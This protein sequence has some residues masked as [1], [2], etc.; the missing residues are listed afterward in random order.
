MSRIET[1]PTIFRDAS[2]STTGNREITARVIFWSAASRLSPGWAT[3]TSVDITSR[4]ASAPDTLAR[5]ASVAVNMPA[6]WPS[7]TTGM[8]RM[9]LSFISCSAS[10]IP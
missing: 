4:T 7:L 8:P 5:S 1:I 2:R 9:P 3:T 10:S 6:M